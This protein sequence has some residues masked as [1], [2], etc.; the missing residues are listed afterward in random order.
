VRARL[1]GTEVAVQLE[2]V[3]LA[4]WQNVTTGLVLGA[5]EGDHQ[6]GTATVMPA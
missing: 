5:L 2:P 1:P 3:D 4:A 6:V